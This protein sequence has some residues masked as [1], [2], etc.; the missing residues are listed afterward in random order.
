MSVRGIDVSD[1]QGAIDWCSVAA[2]DLAYA[3]SQAT[4]GVDRVAK[5][6]AGNWSAIAEVGLVRGASHVFQPDADAQVQAERFLS[7]VTLE[8][9]D[10]PP[11]AIVQTRGRVTLDTFITRLQTWLSFIERK[12]QRLPIL[13]TTL[14]LWDSLGQISSFSRFPLWIVDRSMASSPKLPAGW[15]DWLLWQYTDRGDIKGIN[16]PV[17]VSW[18]NSM[19]EGAYRTGVK[20][21]QRQLAER[22]ANPGRL[23]GSY[24]IF[25]QAAVMDFQ[26]SIGE[27]VDGVA[28]PKTW[29]R[30]LDRDTTPLAQ[31][32]T[33]SAI[34]QPH[35]T[36]TA[37][38]IAL[39]D[40]G[41]YY[42]ALH[43]QIQA[44]N[45]LQAQ[46]PAETLTEFARLWR[47]QATASS[48]PIQLVSAVVYYQGSAHQEQAFNWL[49]DRIPSATLAEFARQWRSVPPATIDLIEVARYYRGIPEQMQAIEQLQ[50]QLSTTIL[51]EFARRWRNQMTATSTP[52]RLLD[53]IVYYKGTSHQ[54]EALTWLRQQIPSTV[55]SDFARQWQLAS[56]LPVQLTNVPGSYRELPHQNAALTW[57]QA[58]IPRKTMEEFTRQWRG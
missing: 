36:S 48:T 6:F 9:G 26:R 24:G 55:L 22:G 11:V 1:V 42:Q 2:S 10:L 20:V 25:T 58:Q 32:S 37:Q 4:D 49:Q 17:N 18:F 21:L 38:S 30:L 7:I 57:L 13:Y 29:A 44:L 41:R 12:T 16:A 8:P 19:G 52:I 27:N 28:G 15:Q 46:I 53:A 51:S 54:A 45:W 33:Q 23:D 3:V 35:T 47:N 31:K 43:Q 34:V 39:T 56:A 40:V 5:T 50:R 14:S